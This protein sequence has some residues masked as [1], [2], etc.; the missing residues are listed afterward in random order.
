MNRPTVPGA[1]PTALP[2]V[3]I[4]ILL[5]LAGTAIRIPLLVVPPVVPLIHDDLHMSETQVGL[6][7]GLPLVMFAVASI[8]GSL[9]IARFGLLLVA[10]IGLFT[11]AL[12]SAARSTANDVWTLYAATILMGFG[13]AI[14]Q[15]ALP[16]L[17]R[18]WTPARTWLASAVYTNGMLIGATAG[19]ALTIPVVLPLVGGSW[20]LDI[21]AWAVPG[22]IVALLYATVAPRPPVAHPVGAPQR[23]WPDWRDPLIWLLGATLGTNNG[24]FFAA[25]A[26]IPDYLTSLG[27]GDLIGAAL[28]WLN[29]AQL[30]AS[31]IMLMMAERIQRTVWPFAIFGPLAVLALFGV[32]LGNGLWI[33][34]ST[35]LVGF[36][37]A[38]TFVITF[39]LP[40]ILSPPEDVHRMAAGMFAVS[41][42]L[43]VIVP[44]ICGA[45]WDLTGV[46]WTAFIPVGLCGLCLTVSGTMLSLRSAHQR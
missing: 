11:T 33:V 14:V 32:V 39:G 26:F 37:S 13:I 36:A 4:L 43:A 44:V 16:T 28:G 25:N 17:A 10:T 5:W 9:L 35:A 42:T 1:G 2:L 40:A 12:A 19:S 34:V 22:L 30:I 45:V 6:L 46:P 15:P 27:R 23:W 21:L 31:C 18:V 24:L 7:I 29:G 38:V 20:R 8:P 3:P 41:Y